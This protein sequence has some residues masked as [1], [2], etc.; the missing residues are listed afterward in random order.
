MK[1]VQRICIVNAFCLAFTLSGCAQKTNDSAPLNDKQVLILLQAGSK[2]DDIEALIIKRG[3]A[4]ARDPDSLKTL[5]EAGA[6]PA[7]ILSLVG[8]SDGKP[9]AAETLSTSNAYIGLWQSRIIHRPDTSYSYVNDGI[10]NGFNGY[11]FTALQIKAGGKAI[12]Y[13]YQRDDSSTDQPTLDATYSYKQENDAVTFLPDGSDPNIFPFK[14][15]LKQG[16]LLIRS[17]GASSNWDWTNDP[18]RDHAPQDDQRL[19]PDGTYLLLDSVPQFGWDVHPNKPNA[20]SATKSLGDVYKKSGVFSFSMPSRWRKAPD[21]DDVSSPDNDDDSSPATSHFKGE[22]HPTVVAVTG[23]DIDANFKEF[24]AGMADDASKNKIDCKRGGQTQFETDGGLVGGKE[25]VHLT[26][27]GTNQ[28]YKTIVIYI[29][30]NNGEAFIF[31]CTVDGIDGYGEG[32]AV[33]DACM[34]TLKTLN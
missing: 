19:E 17:S 31:Q 6:T 5:T 1:I 30:V 25:V 27:T 14:I 11:S 33:F 12:L 10:G 24:N 2:S 4:G 8:D 20:S 29:F 7:L 26:G 34:K 28:L 18:A 13:Y 23:S 21:S 9:A 32:E 3:Y 15:W 16:R 22:I